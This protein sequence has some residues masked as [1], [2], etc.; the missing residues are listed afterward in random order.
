MCWMLCKVPG[1]QTICKTLFLSSMTCM[2][3]PRGEEERKRRKILSTN[4]SWNRRH[5]KD[6]YQF[7]AR[8]AALYQES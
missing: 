2:W 6:G 4:T 8:K 3:V 1:L 7:N 5:M